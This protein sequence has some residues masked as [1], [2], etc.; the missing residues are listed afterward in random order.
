MEKINRQL[1]GTIVSDRMD[2]TRVILVER[3]K[4]HPRYEKIYRLTSRYKAHD[5][6]NQYKTGDKVIIQQIRPLSRDKRWE[7]VGLIDAQKSEKTEE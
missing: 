5:E 3:F 1:K 7:V 2:K 4:K 6:N